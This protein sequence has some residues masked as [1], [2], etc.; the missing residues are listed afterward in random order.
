MIQMFIFSVHIYEL[1]I[2]FPNTASVL[3][4]FRACSVKSLGVDVAIGSI[5]NIYNFGVKVAVGSPMT[6][7]LELNEFDSWGTPALSTRGTTA[8]KLSRSFPS[9]SISS[10]A[11]RLLVPCW[12]F[13][14]LENG[15]SLP[16][17]PR[18]FFNFTTRLTFLPINVLVPLRQYWVFVWQLVECILNSLLLL[19]YRF[20][21]KEFGKIWERIIHPR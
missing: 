13:V 20:I 5:I 12:D 6:P 18:I 10:P 8:S 16:K 21:S 1:I 15:H 3:P 2:Y 11:N 19:V 7:R 14:T 4:W 17:K 9:S